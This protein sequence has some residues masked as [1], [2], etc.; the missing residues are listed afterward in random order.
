[1]FDLG[2]SRQRFVRACEA[3]IHERLATLDK[4][5]LLI[6]QLRRVDCMA[7]QSLVV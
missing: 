5:A 2:P 7:V 4:D 6:E 1:M 3:S